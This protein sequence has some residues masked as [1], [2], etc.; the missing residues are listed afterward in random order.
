VVSESEPTTNQ[1]IGSVTIVGLPRAIITDSAGAFTLTDVPAGTYSVRASKGNYSDETK[2][3]TLPADSGVTLRFNLTPDY[4]PLSRDINGTL[5]QD[6]PLCPGSHGNYTC[7]R[8]IFPA[9]HE[10]GVTANL[11]W[12]SS[13]ATLELALLCNDYTW[14][15]TEGL[16]PGT[17][18]IN[19][20]V[21]YTFRILEN[22]KKGQTCEV[23]VLHISGEPQSFRLTI[24]HPN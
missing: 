23:R 16:T 19:G 20:G 21:F 10:R 18:V 15:R 14:A 3:L 11:Y 7:S 1:R 8:Y 9:H 6:D 4:E 17:T 13:D 12:S 2:T 22:A 5:S 24:V